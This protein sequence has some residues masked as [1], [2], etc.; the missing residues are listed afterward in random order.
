MKLSQL[1]NGYIVTKARTAGDYEYASSS[2]KHALGVCNDGKIISFGT[3]LVYV[4]GSVRSGQSIRS[5]VSGDGG[6]PGVGIPLSPTFNGQYIHIGIA[7]ESGKNKLIRCVLGIS[8]VGA[9]S[10]GVPGPQGPPGSDATV[11]KEAVEEVLTGEISSHSHASS[12]GLT[13]AQI[14]TR[15][16]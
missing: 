2:S 10:S 5:R 14:L 3:A 16:L 8:Y 7:L 13:Q 9:A 12:G 1:R 4:S 6:S 15:Q 11:T